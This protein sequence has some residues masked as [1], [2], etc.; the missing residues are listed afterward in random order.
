MNCLLMMLCIWAVVLVELLVIDTT[1]AEVAGM[2][3]FEG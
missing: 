1:F 3:Y 2:W